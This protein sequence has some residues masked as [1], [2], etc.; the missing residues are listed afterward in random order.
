MMQFDTVDNKLI[1]YYS[2][3]LSLS[4]CV[5]LLINGDTLTRKEENVEQLIISSPRNPHATQF[6]KTLSLTSRGYECSKSATCQSAPMVYSTGSS[7][8]ETTFPPPFRRRPIPMPHIRN[9]REP[10]DILVEDLVQPR[11]AARAERP[12]HVPPVVHVDV[13]PGQDD[14]MDRVA[15]LLVED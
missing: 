10:P 12:H 1:N 4:L 7:A 2:L 9:E 6:A 13:V 14:P 5:C 15:R 11:P 8:S 3:I